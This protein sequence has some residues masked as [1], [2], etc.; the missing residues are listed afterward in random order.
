MKVERPSKFG[1]DIEFFNQKDLEASFIKGELHP[2]DLKNAAAEY[3]DKLIKPVR[4]HFE[5]DKKARELY[6]IVKQ[7]KITR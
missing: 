5:K 4:E 3:I 2:V 7:Q 1:G 6:E